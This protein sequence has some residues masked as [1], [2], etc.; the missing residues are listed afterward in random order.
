MVPG[1]EIIGKVEK[2]GAKSRSGAPAISSASAALWIP[3]AGA[4]PAKAVKSSTARKA[5]TFTY[6]AVER[7]G[8]TRTYGGYSTRITVNQDYV[9][10]IPKE[11]PLERAAPLLCAGITTYS[12]LRQFG[13][14]VAIMWNRWLGG[15]G[16][17]GVK[18]ARAIGAQVTR[19]GH[20][21]RNV[22]MP[23]AWRSCILSLRKNRT[24]SKRMRAGSHFI[25]HRVRRALTDNSYLNL[26]RR[27]GTMVSV[28]VPEATS[29]TFVVLPSSWVAG[30]LLVAYRRYP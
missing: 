7:D 21:P 30:G 6:N 3:A 13:S 9:L 1:H 20:S 12:L 23:A 22:T 18:F 2:V 4:K 10:R 26:L 15:L 29:H 8:V 14:G 11:L 27:D 17:M 25:G 28:G 19:P 16:H 5:A 24:R